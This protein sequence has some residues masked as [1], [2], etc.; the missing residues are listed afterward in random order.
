MRKIYSFLWILLLVAVLALPVQAVSGSVSIGASATTLYR[1]DTFSVTAT[2]ST[3]DVIALG[4][5]KLSYN[6][7]ALEMTGGVCHVANAAMTQ[8]LPAQGAG[9][10]MLSGEP[11]A[12]SGVIFTFYFKVKDNAPFGSYT[13]SSSTSIGVD[14]GQSI[15][16]GAATVTIACR[17]AYDSCNR[18]DDNAHELVC[19]GCGDRVTENHNWDSG[20]VTEPADCKKT[21]NRHH[22]CSSCGATKDETIP[23]SQTHAYGS[24]SR[25]NES[26]H[27][28]TCSV[29]GKAETTSHS[30]NGG[31]V[32]QRATCQHTGT[33]KYTCTGC[34]ET[35]IQTIS[36]TDHAYGSGTYVD[37]NSHKHTCQDCGKEVTEEHRYGADWQHDENGHFRR[38]SG[39]GHTLQQADHTPGPKATEDTDQVCT[40]CNRILQPRG[41]HKH[42]YK[43]AWGYDESG[44][45]HTCSEC[46]GKSEVAAHEYD[47]ACDADCNICL[48]TREPEHVAGEEMFSDE[49]G[50]WYGCTACNGKAGFTAHTPG[51]EA[52]VTTAQNCTVCGFEITPVLPHE[53]QFEMQH[54]HTCQVCGEH[55]EEDGF[56]M[57]CFPWHILCIAEAVVF[58]GILIAGFVWFKKRK[59]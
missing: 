36:K 15:S 18:I 22:T 56:C 28:H 48:M 40:V 52:T 14:A 23:V 58:A 21:G 51:P 11:E 13:I 29:C 1:A 8:V 35:K 33:R 46:M 16:S 57:L 47:D 54:T 39:C 53:H 55:R 6:T 26:Q 10:F 45:W 44:H 43:D 17:H 5:V 38:C 3:A 30:W 59:V 42:T 9:T 7:D 49:S 24:W 2:L 12:I 4:T 27:T 25:V 37:E 19:S 31:T 32:T 20:T 50:H 34:G 41:A